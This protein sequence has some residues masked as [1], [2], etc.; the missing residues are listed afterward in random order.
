MAGANTDETHASDG[1]QP[2]LIVI[3]EVAG[4]QKI[5]FQHPI[6]TA[7]RWKVITN[8][9]ASCR[10]PKKLPA[11]SKYRVACTCRAFM[12]T[13]IETLSF[14]INRYQAFKSVNSARFRCNIQQNYRWTSAEKF[15]KFQ[16]ETFCFGI[17]RIFRRKSCV[18]FTVL[19]RKSI[20]VEIN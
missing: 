11:T 19:Q 10:F 4:T 20:Y 6:F 7:T 12:N 18:H 2:V 8:A 14:K 5:Q 16:G 1:Q 15:S 17:L 13:V 3:G 9:T